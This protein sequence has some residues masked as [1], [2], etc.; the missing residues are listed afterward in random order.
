[1][2][3]TL[4]LLIFL[5]TFNAYAEPI[6]HIKTNYYAIN[7]QTSRELR[8][9]MS[10]KGPHFDN[11]RTR[12]AATTQW[13]VNW[14]VSYTSNDYGCSINTVQ[15]QVA[16]EFVYPRWTNKTNAR[17]NIQEKWERFYQALVA[18]EQTHANHGISAAKQIENQLARLSSSNQCANLRREV[19]NRAQQ[20]IH[21][22]QNEDIQFDKR[23]RHGLN[24]GVR[25]P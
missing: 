11:T 15:T 13:W 23:T 12:Y 16:I 22:Y 19:N 4:S 1:M 6:V 14:D 20:I 3:I 21:H 8:R 9:E 2:K 7:G 24:E 18:H 5:I 17:P 10:T 25:L